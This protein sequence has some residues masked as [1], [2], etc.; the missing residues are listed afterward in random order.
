MS[1]SIYAA[2]FLRSLLSDRT[3]PTTHDEI[4]R[5]IWKAITPEFTNTFLRKV[6]EQ[7]KTD[8]AVHQRPLLL[9]MLDTIDL[10]F[11][12]DMV[13]QEVLQTIDTESLEV[14][15]HLMWPKD[16]RIDQAGVFMDTSQDTT[17]GDDNTDTPP[18]NNLSHFDEASICVENEQEEKP[19]GLDYSIRLSV[20]VILSRIGYFDL[21]STATDASNSR[22]SNSSGLRLIQSRIRSAVI[23]FFSTAVNYPHSEQQ[24]SSPSSGWNYLASS[25]MELTRRRFRLLN[26]MAVPENEEFLSSCLFSKE[27]EHE[28]IVDTLRAEIEN[29]NKRL[30]AVAEKEKRLEKEKSTLQGAI[31]SQSVRFWREIN[32]VKKSAQE[33]TNSKISIFDAERKMAEHRAHELSKRL[34]EAENRVAEADQCA[35]DSHEAETKVRQDHD[36]IQKKLQEREEE[37]E[38]LRRDLGLREAKISEIQN[39]LGSAEDRLVSMNTDNDDLRQLIGDKEADIA[40]L[41]EARE[42]M[43]RNLDCLFGDLVKLCHIYEA[44]EKSEAELQSQNESL[45]SQL[46]ES[47]SKKE[48]SEQ[49]L[50]R[51]KEELQ[52]EKEKL[53]RKLVKYKEKLEAERRERKGVETKTKSYKP[54]AYLNHLHDS[55]NSSMNNTRSYHEKSQKKSSSSSRSHKPRSKDKENDY[56]SSYRGTKKADKLYVSSQRSCLRMPYK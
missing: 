20:A 23:E 45:S 37:N 39:A 49:K 3:S 4:S 28:N 8:V 19:V 54:V 48:V 42:T 7:A 6:V 12:S 44:K 26:A 22:T 24:S 16:I 9:C 25:S 11:S 55:A 17:F 34:T 51:E 40:E 47:R 35:R 30:E 32:R 10:A 1:L 13:L 53:E 38:E 41:K 2:S 52:L 43:E 27:K 36:E 56:D 5:S 15:I 29:G 50:F 14:L 33:Q 46:R 21:S 31:D 18:V